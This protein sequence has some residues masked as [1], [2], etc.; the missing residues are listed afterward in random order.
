MIDIYQLEHLVTIADTGNIS[1]AAKKLHLSQPGLTR[2][3][4]RLEDQLHI[5]LFNRTKNKVSLN[6]NGKLAV[7]YAKKILNDMNSMVEDLQNFDRD[8]RIISIGSCAPAPV[9]GLTYLCHQL[10][11]KNHVENEIISNDLDLINGLNN[12]KYTFVVLNRP[13]FDED[14]ICMEL[15]KENLYISVP[16]YHPLALHKETTFENINGE[17]VLLLSKIGFWNE[18]CIKKLPKSHL[19]TQDSPSVFD[20]IVKASTLPNFRTNITMLRKSEEKNRISIPISD[21][22]AHITYY[23]IMKK[24][25]KTFFDITQNHLKQIN[26][27]MI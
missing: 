4:Q 13:I 15:V 14:Y 20:E 22:E 26:W 27:E 19:L 9:W 3:M 6:D 11:P 16:D 25:T 2:S 7:Q 8:K 23:F 18:L 17:S 5:T 10:F 12:H 24:E 21:D 1:K